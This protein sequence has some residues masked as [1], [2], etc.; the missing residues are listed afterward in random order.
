MSAAA[1]SRAARERAV[2]SD[3][4]IET[5]SGE[6]GLGEISDGATAVGLP[7]VAA[8]GGWLLGGRGPAAISGQPQG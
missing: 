6:L 3:G 5:R 8:V 1:S 7:T 4:T 2:S